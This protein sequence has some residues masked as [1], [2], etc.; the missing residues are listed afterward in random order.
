M[1]LQNGHFPSHF[2]NHWAVSRGVGYSCL[3][4][5]GWVFSS[6]KL[7]MPLAEFVDPSFGPGPVRGVTGKNITGSLL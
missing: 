4:K 3:F 6:P 5:N 7:R 1:P 2:I